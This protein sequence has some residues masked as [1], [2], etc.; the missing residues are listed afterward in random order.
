VATPEQIRRPILCPTEALVV[1]MRHI[2]DSFYDI[3]K[4]INY[5][6]LAGESNSR[7]H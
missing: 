5:C 1:N 2:G 6:S 7:R 3:R 4:L